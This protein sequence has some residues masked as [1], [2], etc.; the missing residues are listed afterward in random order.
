VFETQLE[1]EPAAAVISDHLVDFNI[2]GVRPLAPDVTVFFNMKRRDDWETF[3][4]KAEGAKP[5]LVVEVTSQAT[6]KNDLGIKVDFYHRAKVPLYLIADAVGR[7]TKRRVTLIGHQYQRNGYKRITPDEQGRVYLKPVRLWIG[8]TRDPGKGYERLAC[9]DPA[10][11][12]EVGDHAA[13]V[14]DRKLAWAV[15][16]EQSR[17][18]AEAE[19]LVQFERLRAEAEARARAQAEARVREL[20]A[21][22]KSSRRQKR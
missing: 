12:E 3:D 2:L 6:R 8:V 16:A 17:A 4:V 5:A 20:E 9:Y 18:R 10:T 1:D 7:G 19:A 21:A 15:A 22:L 11:G 13:I 14:K